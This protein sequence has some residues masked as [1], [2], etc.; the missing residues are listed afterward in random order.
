MQK[1]CSLGYEFTTPGFRTPPYAFEK[2]FLGDGLK[3]TTLSRTPSHEWPAA[4]PPYPYQE[5][6]ESAFRTPK[7]LEFKFDS[8]NEETGFEQRM[9]DPSTWHGP[10]LDFGAITNDGSA[11]LSAMPLFVPPGCPNPYQGAL[12]D[13]Q[14]ES[15]MTDK[16]HVLSEQATMQEKPLLDSQHAEQQQQLQ[17]QGFQQNIQHQHGGFKKFSDLVSFSPVPV[18]K[19]SSVQVQQQQQPQQQVFVFEAPQVAAS[20]LTLPESKQHLIASNGIGDTPM[21]A[22]ESQPMSQDYSQTEP[23]DANNGKKPNNKRKR[24]QDSPAV[25]KH[26]AA[27]RDMLQKFTDD[28][29]LSGTLSSI[30]GLPVTLKTD[31]KTGEQTLGKYTL[32]QR[33][34]RIAKFKAKFA[35]KRPTGPRKKFLYASRSRFAKSRKRRGGRFVSKGNQSP[36]DDDDYQS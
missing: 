24:K 1:D 28:M 26:A 31:A 10:M 23:S 34:L 11:I 20:P 12:F 22:A 14:Q 18:Q 15:A 2:P 29:D 3:P 27:L 16:P 9:Q 6:E 36:G 21:V 4:S 33:K 30:A 25:K 8:I 32:S 7:R 5:G 13:T 35:G 19:L 17:Q